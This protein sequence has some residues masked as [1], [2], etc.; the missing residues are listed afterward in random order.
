MTPH[1]IMAQATDELAGVAARIDAD[2]IAR[3]AELIAS[4]GHVMLCGCGR[5]GLQMQGL[6][7]RLHHL[8]LNASMQGDMAAPPLG[9]KDLFVVS[10]GPTIHSSQIQAHRKHG[11][12]PAPCGL[13]GLAET[14]ILKF[15]P[16]NTEF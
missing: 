12:I 14:D 9:P 15:P 8:G 11:A 7:M 16:K 13:C 2:E 10:A 6:A 1:Q 5:E 4:A 3:A